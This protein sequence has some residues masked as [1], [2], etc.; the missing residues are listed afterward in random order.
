MGWD[1]WVFGIATGGLYNAGKA[2]YNG[3]KKVTGIVDDVE[4]AADQAGV[5]IAKIGDTVVELGDSLESFI[6]NLDDLLVIERLVPRSRSDLWD[7]EVER[8]DDLIEER[9]SLRSQ[10]DTLR[11]EIESTT[12]VD[13]P[14]GYGASL[15]KWILENVIYGPMSW[16]YGGSTSIWMDLGNSGRTKAFKIF[17]LNSKI[18]KIEKEIHE[19]LYNEPGILP[20]T[21]YNVKETIERFNT[22][23]QP[24]IEDILDTV[25]E[26]LVE[27]RDI[28]KEVKKLFVTETKEP[29]D[30][31]TLPSIQQEKLEILENEYSVLESVLSNDLVVAKKFLDLKAEEQPGL[32]EMLTETAS[33]GDFQKAS[34][35][36][37]ISSGK[38]RDIALEAKAPIASRDITDASIA[39]VKED[40]PVTVTDKIKSPKLDLVSSGV[41]VEGIVPNF[42]KATM[43]PNIV[44]I[45]S[46]FTENK[47]Y[48]YNNK[49]GFQK[50]IIKQN[51]IDLSKVKWKIDGIKYKTVETPGVIPTTLQE[52]KEILERFNSEEQPRIEDILDSINDNLVESKE[53]MGK[54]NT[55]FGW[56]SDFASKHERLVKIAG[57]VALGALALTLVL[58]PILIIRVIIFGL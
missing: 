3:Y 16:I 35:K 9:S 51:E 19:I 7:E 20:T 47:Y 33:N 18:I 37:V 12:S 54:V 29:I 25:D 55:A 44:K 13:V 2:A 38:D 56:I 21:V 22:I 8:L 40:S 23:E 50:A 34:L 32:L 48:A 30:I 27:S 58:I 52:I 41:Y 28:L 49:Y 11:S 45:M 24:K 1:D 39:N 43:Q 53:A 57:G 5:A 15:Q 4:N 46:G 17:N 42:S 14:S 10:I 26:N 36:D 31:G 6:D